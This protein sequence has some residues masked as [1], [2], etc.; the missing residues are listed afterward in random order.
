MGVGVVLQVG[1]D[2][3]VVEIVR[4]VVVDEQQ[5]ERAE[6]EGDRHAGVEAGVLALRFA[7]GR[8]LGFELGPGAA[9]E[10]HHDGRDGAE[11]GPAR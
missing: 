11:Q 9:E 8:G 7:R 5:G 2:A 6:G 10:A 3:S 1:L 4:A